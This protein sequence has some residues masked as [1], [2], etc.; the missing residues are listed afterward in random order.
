MLRRAQHPPR[1]CL[2]ALVVLAVLLPSASEGRGL[3]PGCCCARHLLTRLAAGSGALALRGGGGCEAED[4]DDDV[5]RAP[6]KAVERILKQHAP[7][8]LAAASDYVTKRLR[9]RAAAGAGRCSVKVGAGNV[10]VQ[11]ADDVP[12]NCGAQD[13]EPK[14]TP[15]ERMRR[16]LRDQMQHED[17]LGRQFFDAVLQRNF[18]RAH[19]LLDEGADPDWR[20]PLHHLNT[21]LHKVAAAGDLESVRFLLDN[22]ASV[23]V[24]NLFGDSPLFAS[25][26]GAGM[27]PVQGVCK[28][29]WSASWKGGEKPSLAVQTWAEQVYRA[30]KLLLDAGALVAHSNNYSNT[31]LHKAAANGFPRNVELLL[32]HGANV[33]AVNEAGATALHL[34]AFGGHIHSVRVLVQN[35]ADV[36]AQDAELNTPLWEAHSLGRKEV[37]AYLRQFTDDTSWDPNAFDVT[38]SEEA[39]T[40]D[41]GKD[42][43]DKRTAG[44]NE[45]RGEET[46]PQTLEELGALLMRHAMDPGRFVLNAKS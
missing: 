42:S 44:N 9:E 26:G 32:R 2:T 36:N 5:D 20:H 4:E 8:E 24:L 11:F 43:N 7:E 38:S 15:I 31:P 12:P 37:L 1:I 23:H 28:D 46:P 22:G 27:E 6:R 13:D 30:S 41:V 39:G 21:A 16:E 18:T 25:A 34:A 10:E 19:T 35:G 33:N 45:S 3:R 40:Q 14:L 17:S 29:L